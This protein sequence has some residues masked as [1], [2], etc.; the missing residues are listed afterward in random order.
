MVNCHH[1]SKNSNCPVIPI[2]GTHVARSKKGG[3]Y[4]AGQE[5]K[6]FYGCVKFIEPIP[7][8]NPITS[9]FKFPS[10]DW[11]DNIYGSYVSMVLQPRLRYNR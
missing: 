3:K 5:M 4:E 11:V 1:H 8:P 7:D 2:Y 9:T 10:G 6:E